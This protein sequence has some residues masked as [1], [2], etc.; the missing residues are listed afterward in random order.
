MDTFGQRLR[1]E[2]IN[3]GWTG[4]ELGKMLNVTKV[5]ISK[6]ELDER[7]PD[8]DTLVK[9]SDIFDISLD[10]LLCRTN[11]RKPLNEMITKNNYDVI[12]NALPTEL[13]ELMNNAKDLDS[14][15]L[16]NLNNFLTSIKVIKKT[17]PNGNKLEY[18]QAPGGRKLTEEEELAISKYL[19]DLNNNKK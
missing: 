5:A 4:E 16:E 12:F 15:Q 8:K 3:K 6:W 19:N 10:Y 13:K 1:I 14:K 18:T 9:I 2:R 11:E 17:L 7:F